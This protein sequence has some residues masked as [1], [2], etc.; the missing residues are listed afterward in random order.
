M[1]F[2]TYIRIYLT[3]CI[4]STITL[5]LVCI[6]CS[7]FIAFLCH[8]NVALVANPT[9]TGTMNKKYSGA[10]VM[11]PKHE[12]ANLRPCSEII[13]MKIGYIDAVIQKDRQTIGQTVWQSKDLLQAPCVSNTMQ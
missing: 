3:L 4:L 6:T 7:L 9:A 1:S 10:I 12:V 11:P 2:P 13:G 5:R 8:E